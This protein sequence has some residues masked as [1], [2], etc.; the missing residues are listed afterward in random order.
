[1]KQGKDRKREKAREKGKEKRKGKGREG[2]ELKQVFVIWEF[3]I[4]QGL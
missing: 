4:S 3:R 2:T 1:M